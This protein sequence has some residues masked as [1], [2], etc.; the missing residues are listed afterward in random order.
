[1]DGCNFFSAQAKGSSQFWQELHKIKHLFKWGALF[2]VKNGLN[3]R[4][5]QDCWLQDVP[6]KIAYGDL[7]CFARDPECVVVDCWVYDD[8]FMNFRRALSIN[9]Y[10]RWLQL[11]EELNAIQRQRM[12]PR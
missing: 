6:L 7:F 2:K 11:K 10:N 4:F 12:D 8:W 9:E 1:M 3:C 5:W